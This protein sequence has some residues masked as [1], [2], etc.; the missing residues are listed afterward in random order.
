MPENSHSQI[1]NLIAAND[2]QQLTLE[3]KN[4]MIQEAIDFAMG[5]TPMGTVKAGKGIMSILK[6]L[7]KG[8]PKSKFGRGY[9]Q[10]SSRYEQSQLEEALRA[11][12]DPDYLQ[13]IGKEHRYLASKTTPKSQ[14]ELI[15]IL[16]EIGFTKPEISPYKPIVP[17]G[18]W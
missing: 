14:N 15:K 11:T 7:F 10:G 13:T 16:E 6:N 3:D 9:G 1:D 12:Y 5:S 18:K 17:R 2:L 8:K 4:S